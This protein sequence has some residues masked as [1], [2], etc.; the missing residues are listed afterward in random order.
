MA[1]VFK[2]KRSSTAAK[3]PTTTDLASGEIG[4]NM[5]DQKVY[6][7]NGTSVVQVGAGKLSAIGETSIS[8]PASTQYLRHNGT[9]WVNSAIQA[10]DVPTLNQST[11]GSAASLTTGRTIA[12][13]GDVSWTSPT[14][15]GSANVTAAATLATV[16]ANVG[17]FGSASAIPVITVNA[18]GL[19]TAVSTATVAGGQYFGS[20]ATKAI[21]YNSATIAEN[22]TV[23]AG[24]NGLS[25]GPISISSGFTVTIESGANWVIV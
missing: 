19:V 6:I 4:V 10:A 14:F 7:N 13:T 12:M 8:S 1:N 22:V 21:A 20:A 24:N 11:T 15:N 2:P 23:T 25:A 18:K 5:A 3:V 9:N 17:S 16:N